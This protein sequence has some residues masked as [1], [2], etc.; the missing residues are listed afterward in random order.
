MTEGH[1]GF[2]AGSGRIGFGVDHYHEYAPEAANPIRLIWLAAARTHATFTCGA[3]LDHDLADL[4]LDL[5][6]H[7]LVP[8]HPWQWWN[9]LSV[10]F[11]A[12]PLAP[13]AR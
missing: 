7:L 5:A 4:G 2:V 9:K 13:Y 1:P 11:A 3:G 8:V 12:D 6:D 10:T